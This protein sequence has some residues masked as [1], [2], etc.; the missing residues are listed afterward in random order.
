MSRVNADVHLELTH[1]RS[2]ETFELTMHLYRESAGAYTYDD[3]T[4]GLSWAEIAAKSK[5]GRA[6][7]NGVYDW[8]FRAVPQNG[9][10]PDPHASGEFHWGPYTDIVGIGDG[11]PDLYARGTGNTSYFSAGTGDW[12]TPFKARTAGPVLGTE[13]NSP[14]YKVFCPPLTRCHAF[15][16]GS[17]VTDLSRG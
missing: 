17:T 8:S 14:Y 15:L 10:G 2:G 5:L 3:R 7:Y 16:P 1:R 13:P 9:I 12:K 6:A 4:F 11:G